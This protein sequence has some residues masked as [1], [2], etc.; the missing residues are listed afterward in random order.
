MQGLHNISVVVCWAILKIDLAVFKILSHKNSMLLEV[1]EDEDGYYGNDPLF[2][3][4]G[5]HHHLCC[6][7]WFRFYRVAFDLTSKVS[8]QPTEELVLL[9]FTLTPSSPLS[10]YKHLS[11]THPDQPTTI[12]AEVSVSRSPHEYYN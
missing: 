6:M 5:Q 11:L 12:E 4:G 2:G 7:L 9:S 8:F 3:N 1:G 10:L